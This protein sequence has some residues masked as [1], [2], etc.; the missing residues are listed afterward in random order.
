MLFVSHDRA[1]LRGLSNRVL[2]LGGESGTE[3]QPHPYPGSYVEYVE[4]TG[5]E[6]PGGMG[7]VYRA[8]DTQLKRQ[9]A[10]KILP[11]SL[12]TDRDR[13]ARFQRE[14]EVLA[15]LNH[16]NIGAIY[17]FEHEGDG[18]RAGAG[19]GRGTDAC[20]EAR[21]AKAWRHTAR[22][23]A[24][25]RAAD[26]GR[27]RCG[28]RARHRPS[29]SEAGEH[30]ALAGWRG[31]G[32]RLRTRETRDRWGWTGGG[33]SGRAD[34]LAD[35]DG[36]DGRRRAAGDGAV[37]VAGAGARQGGRQAH[38]HLGIRVRAVRDAHRPPR[39]QRRDDLRCDRRDSR[40]RAGLLAPQRFNAA[41]HR[42]P[43]DARARQGSEDAAARHRRRARSRRHAAPDH[44]RRR[45][46]R[47]PAVGARFERADLLRAVRHTGCARHGPRGGGAWQ[48]APADCARAQRRGCEPRRAAHRGV[49]VS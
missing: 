31:E 21:R 17:G 6:A 37:H 2:E 18:P 38:G 32:A 41:A 44:S 1:F 30:R 16:P 33:R 7:Q 5:H 11:P 34:Q 28:A 25:D 14:A 10:I 48:S 42:P 45:R 20:R 26:R 29:R 47:E 43:A 19:V 4:R 8:T 13:L 46:S 23:S 35:D 36:A 22:R 9:V 27:A 49:P 12:A 39:V 24:G 3:A 40:T 15:S